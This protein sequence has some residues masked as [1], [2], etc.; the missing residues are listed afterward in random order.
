MHKLIEWFARNSVAANLL[1]LA[2]FMAGLQAIFKDLTLEVF[3]SFELDVVTISVNYP[4]ASPSEVESA[5][6]TRVEQAISDLEGIK[7]ITSNA[8]EA[9]ASI[10]IELL[11]QI[12]IT[13]FIA[14]LK[15]RI[16]TLTTLPKE[17]ERPIVMEAR[18]QRETISVVLSGDLNERQLHH[19]ALEIHDDILH[20]EAVSQ[21][22]IAGIRAYEIGIEVSQQNLKRYQLTLDEIAN[23]INQSS[24]NI[25]A[26]SLWTTAGELRLR[27]MGQAYK[28]KDFENII[29]RS[30]TAGG[31][32]R[33][34]DIATVKDGFTEDTLYALFDG[35]KAAIIPV[36]RVGKQS[37][38]EVATSVI[39]YIEQKRAELPPN[40]KLS[41][42]KNRSKIV[43]ERLQTLLN[44]ALQGGILILLLLSL[45]LRPAIAFWVSVGIPI[46][47]MGALA[48]MAIMGVSINLITLFAFIVVLGIVVDDAIVTAE[49]IYSHQ[50]RG[51]NSLEAVIK[52]TQEIS[53][54]VTFG[55]LTTIAAFIPLLVLAGNRGK[56]FA[57]IP[58]VI[59]PVLI[60]SLIESKLILPT[61]LRHLKPLNAKS[62]NPLTRLQQ[63]IAR[64]MELFTT[65]I[66][67]P[68]LGLALKG[69]YF[70][71]SLFLSMLVLA[72]ILVMSGNYPYTFMPRVQS[73]YSK[74]TLLMPEGTPIE[75]TEA[76]IDH[77]H[78]QAR[79]L[80][81]KYIN[82]KTQQSIIKHI[83]VSVGSTGGGLKRATSGKSH[84]GQVQMELISPE[85]RTMTSTELT[86][87][88]RKLIG[89][90]AGKQQLNFRS[91]IVHGGAPIDIQLQ[92][93]DFKILN[94][95][96]NA[97]KERIIQRYRAEG[98][99]NIKTSFDGGKDEL[100]ITLKPNAELLGINLSQLGQQIRH[101]FYGAQAQRI[102]RGKDDIK[103]MVRFPKQERRSLHD[104]KQLTISTKNGTQIPITELANL[105]VI[106][107]FA[108][109]KRIDQK[110]VVNI[111]ADIDKTKGNSQLM[112]KEIKGWVPDILSHYPG[113]SLSFEGEQREQKEMMQSVLTGLIFALFVIYSLLAIPFKSYLQPLIV[114][115]IIPFS[116]IGALFGHML[117]G[118]TLSISSFMGL[119]ALTG[120]VVNDSLVLVDYINQQREKGITLIKAVSL[121]GKVRFRPIL[122]T[123]LTTFFGLMPLILEKSTQAQFLIPMAVSLGFGILFATFIT[124]ILIP[125]SYLILEDFKRIGRWVMK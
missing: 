119:L 78:Q 65:Y 58:I 11:S 43:K 74:A 86:R 88:W 96:A 67:Q 4:G 9:Q 46:S 90:I 83:F 60:F 41:Y 100:H 53:I 20:L 118:M 23:K 28:K 104:L 16:E 62:I 105:D 106:S 123:S 84:L 32:I 34:G 120:V 19:L 87:E 14:D 24:V 97:I 112:I 6:I 12:D 48:V 73:E 52:G 81:K 77:I 17:A 31:I 94:E 75:I 21:A 49:N 85:Q 40:V 93:N 25:P 51:T 102:Q 63:A 116:F 72:V 122:L 115:S 8:R 56:I 66:Y 59:I 35:K 82:P 125:C 36:Y 7:Q 68:T 117:M 47:F 103:I 3:P 89:E 29:I 92:G 39:Q 79:K 98:A 15:S 121:A 109:I 114:M 111:T 22:S 64:G 5:V 69:R 13:R 18:R 1:M 44:S 76:H 30:N 95:A 124:L 91:E 61:H 108:R 101:A 110:R 50:R 57:F 45:F 55:V 27:V 71:L 38:I 2:I 26:G 42:W 37:T 33:L 70:T 10:S 54:P 107:G 113:V 99:F 80:Q